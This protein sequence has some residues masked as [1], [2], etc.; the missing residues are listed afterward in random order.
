[1]A[2]ER[3]SPD[4]TVA[5]IAAKQHGVVSIGQLRDAGLSDDA[6]LERVRAG[7]LHR[8][9]RGVYAVGH[10]AIG[11]KGRCM[12]ATLA[13]AATRAA[14]PAVSHRSAAALWQL[15]PPDKQ[16]IDVSLPSQ[17]GRRRRDGIRIHRCESLKPGD[18]THLLGI[19]V[20]TPARTLADLRRAVSPPEL[21]RA[22]RQA[23]VL[24]LATGMEN[25]VEGTRSELERRF[26]R[27]CRRAG[28]P[29]PEV[30][31]RIGGLTVDFLWRDERLIVETDGYRYHR[32]RQAFEDDRGRD[33]ELRARG[34]E[35]LRLSYRQ[36]SD[37]PERVIGALRRVLRDVPE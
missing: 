6:V 33:L 35:V 15:L 7:R 9:H 32:G 5:Q 28:L 2:E 31:V 22:I 34:Y 18:A 24:G 1:M 17:S 8:I 19:P 3:A 16:P 21:R 11:F 29:A 23:D 20:T 30:N 26:L 12:A 36:V 25:V 14:E 10:L 27:L 13:I 37:R 4:R